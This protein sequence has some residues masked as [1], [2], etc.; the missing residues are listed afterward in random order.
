M[1]DFFALLERHPLGKGVLNACQGGYRRGGR[2]RVG[3]PL[4]WN[5]ASLPGAY[6]GHRGR[7]IG[8]LAN[9]LRHRP[10]GI[11]QVLPQGA[12]SLLLIAGAEDL[13]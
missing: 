10:A 4:P 5:P 1:L 13:Q 7:S 2:E 3:I 9:E 12:A 11:H 8:M 6:M